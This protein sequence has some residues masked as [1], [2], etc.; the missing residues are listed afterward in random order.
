MCRNLAGLETNVPDDSAGS[1]PFGTR[2]ETPGV[3]LMP[4]AYEEGESLKRKHDGQE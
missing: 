4:E 1:K 2:L 3:S